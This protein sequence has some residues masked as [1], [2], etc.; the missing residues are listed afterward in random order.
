[1]GWSYSIEWKYNTGS[2]QLSNMTMTCFILVAHI[3]DVIKAIQKAIQPTKWM[4]KEEIPPTSRKEIS[5]TGYLLPQTWQT[6][7]STGNNIWWVCHMNN[8]G[9]DTIAIAYSLAG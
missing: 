7:E 1:M 9:C 6:Y 3:Q 4:A 8:N 2:I 5:F